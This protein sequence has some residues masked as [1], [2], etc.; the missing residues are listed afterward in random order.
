MSTHVATATRAIQMKTVIL[1]STPPMFTDDANTAWA[2]E[3]PSMSEMEGDETPP[4]II[5]VRAKV[6]ARQHQERGQGDDE[7]R[8]L[9]L[10]QDPAVDIADSQRHQQGQSQRPPR[11]LC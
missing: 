7:A 3:K 1:T 8:K 11:R 10:H 4:P 2:D 5:R 9:G 6:Q